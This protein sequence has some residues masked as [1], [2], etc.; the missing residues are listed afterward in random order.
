MSI[1]DI[2]ELSMDEKK[3]RQSPEAIEDEALDNV[4][5]GADFARY[6]GYEATCRDCGHKWTSASEKPKKC[7][8]CDSTNINVYSALA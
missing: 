8:N 4:T 6:K 3:K 2:K 5:G 1:Q 7:K